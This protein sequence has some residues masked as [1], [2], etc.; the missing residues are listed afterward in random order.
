M[1]FWAGAT[2]GFEKDGGPRY[3]VGSMA[4]VE[5]MRVLLRAIVES[6]QQSYHQCW[7]RL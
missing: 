5:C 2:T 7:L 3:I 1:A 6:D 4:A